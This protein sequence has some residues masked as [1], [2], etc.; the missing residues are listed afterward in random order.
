VELLIKIKKIIPPYVR[1]NRLIR[2]IPSPS[3]EAGN[4]IS[5]LREVIAAEMARRGLRCKCIRCR[6]VGHQQKFKNQNSK[7]KIKLTVRKYE[8]SSGVEYFISY[9]SPDQKILYAFV[10][11]RI[12]NFKTPPIL[13]ELENAALIRELHTYGHLV[14]IDQNSPGATQH[15]GLG[16]KLMAEAE[17]IAR[18][19][20]IKKMAV[21]S[22]V[23]VREYYKKLG[24][25]RV[26]TYMV[27]SL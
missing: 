14:P 7:I 25:E 27:K 18:K 19:S 3:I 12:P 6:E 20:G 13:P 23:G 11:L 5:N 16:K 2:D 1:V 21:I 9:E 8:A 15:L 22:G 17:K 26:G 10:R 4:K 24:Y